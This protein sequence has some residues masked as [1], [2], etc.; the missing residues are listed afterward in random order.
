MGNQQNDDGVHVKSTAEGGPAQKGGLVSGDKILAINGRSCQTMDV[1]AIAACVGQ[2]AQGVLE[3]QVVFD[4]LI[5]HKNM[6]TN[7]SVAQRDR[8][9]RQN[10]AG[11]PVHMRPPT[12]NRQ[13]QA[14]QKQLSKKDQVKRAKEDAKVE[15]KRVKEAIKQAKR[16]KKGGK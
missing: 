2:A 4:G 1:T 8:H 10:G 14:P 11:T 12:P 9:Y 7:L 15:A 13:Q 16:D 3:M 6:F 5:M